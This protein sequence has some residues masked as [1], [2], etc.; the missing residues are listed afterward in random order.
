MMVVSL[1][2][3]CALAAH[4]LRNPSFPQSEFDQLKKLLVTSMEAQLSDPGSRASEAMGQHFNIYPK[5]DPRYSS[6]RCSNA[7]LAIS[8]FL[9]AISSTSFCQLI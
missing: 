1:F 8:N 7:L 6:T 3:E 2:M 9:R 4:T 5:G